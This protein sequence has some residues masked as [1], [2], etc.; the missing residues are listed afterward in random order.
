MLCG[1]Y[2]CQ[3][4]HLAKY[5]AV[6]NAL[7]AHTLRVQMPPITVFSLL[8]VALRALALASRPSRR[9]NARHIRRRIR[10]PGPRRAFAER[11]L[12][13]L[14]SPGVLPP[15]RPLLYYFFSNGGAFVHEQLVAATRDAPARHS[16]VLRAQ[17]G[18][19]FD[20][21]PA[22]IRTDTAADLFSRLSP[23][24]FLRPL[25][26]LTFHALVRCFGL[27][28]GR[29]AACVGRQ[30]ADAY[31]AAMAGA[32]TCSGAPELYVFS[33]DDPLCDARPLAE[34]VIERQRAGAAVRSK[35]FAVS[36]HVGHLRCH[37]A[38]YEAALAD[39][40]AAGRAHAA[41]ARSAGG[42]A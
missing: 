34:L 4:K 32:P 28:G 15:S 12:S 19:A 31:W 21:A 16:A 30:R 20:S 25:L 10:S 40:I 33:D 22:A 6:V 23:F 29:F 18:C 14:R 1:W 8:C 35:R 17:A 26:R 36:E 42:G 39:F 27:L 13:F 2:G 37:P 41:K 5:S 11:L 3:D 38:E 24:A 7:G 9:A